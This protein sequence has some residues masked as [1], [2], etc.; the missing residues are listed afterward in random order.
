MLCKGHYIVADR[1]LAAN[2]TTII[3]ARLGEAQT[4]KL[5]HDSLLTCLTTAALLVNFLNQ[6]TVETCIFDF[7]YVLY[8][9]LRTT[10]QDF[11]FRLHA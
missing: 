4:F 3:G 2:D 7:N 8:S 1:V 6:G 10:L 5:S 9:Q 11:D